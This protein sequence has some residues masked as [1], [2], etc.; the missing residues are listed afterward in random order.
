MRLME[1]RSLQQ[2][3]RDCAGNL[4][5]G[6]PD[7]V[8]RRV[9]TDSRAV[10]A[11]DLFVALKGDRFD[12]HDYVAEVA[13]R[14]AAGVL[15]SASA[16]DRLLPVPSVVVQNT[17]VALGDLARAY[18]QDVD[19]RV[20]AVGGS[21]GK[22]STK[23]LVAAVLQQRYRTLRSEASFNNDIGVPLTVLRL[24]RHHEMAVFEVG[25]NHPGELEPLVRLVNPSIGIITSLGR[26]HLEFFGDMAGVCR[27]EGALAEGLPP[28]GTL[29][30]G[31]DNAWGEEIERRT[32]ATVVR[33]GFSE[34]CDWRVL[35]VRLSMRGT[36]FTVASPQ[37][38]Y[39]GAYRVGLLGR[40]HAVN[41]LF[42]IALGAQLG[43]SREEIQRG[44]VGAAPAPRRMELRRCGPVHVLDDCYNANADS[45]VAALQTLAALPCTGS[46]LAV[47]G[48]MAELGA[49]AESA[50]AEA[51][52]LAA[53]LNL[54]QLL[55][56]GQMAAVTAAAARQAGLH[57]VLE[58]GTIEAVSDA[59]QKVT[60]PGDLI[61][62]KASRRMRLE[63][64]VDALCKDGTMEAH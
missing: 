51:G 8:V 35:E 33:V 47:L 27:E 26:E 23:E 56:I 57:R 61:L 28:H 58:F 36:D 44:L 16:A 24:E 12:G 46:R 59:L 25:T 22:T 53:E 14:G 3:A 7:T 48:D 60:R 13:R 50:H 1:P 29:Y 63:R 40:H 9:C 21:N 62:L 31:A 6:G 30:F 19:P 42:A 54:G 64:V 17:R 4:Q 34:S 37:A 45:T 49:Q 20:I 39:A 2:V 41:A 55:V 43:L 5:G 11:G 15:V 52:R 38:G 10:Q 32:Q 18:R